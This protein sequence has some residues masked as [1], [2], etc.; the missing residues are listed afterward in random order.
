MISDDAPAFDA[1]IEM[2]MG[3]YGR[4]RPSDL[5]LAAWWMALE[6]WPLAAVQRALQGHIRECKYAPTPAD[7]TERLEGSDGRPAAA[8]AWA[9]ALPAHDEARTVVWTPEMAAA[10]ALA[11]PLLQ[12]RDPVGARQAFVAAYERAV[13]EARSAQQAARWEVSL[14]HDPEQRQMALDAARSRGWLPAKVVRWLAPATPLQPAQALSQAP[15]DPAPGMLLL[16][17]ALAS[18]RRQQAQAA[19]EQA[20]IKATLREEQAAARAEQRARLAALDKP[21][22]GE[23]TVGDTQ[24][25]K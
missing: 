6:R 11:R 4:D 22:P 21:S 12:A 23:N 24:D 15:A 10:F 13:G 20:A 16:R 5:T 9:L 19:A 8:E 2:A 18:A 1:E 7:I 25:T 3:V 17:R 14:G